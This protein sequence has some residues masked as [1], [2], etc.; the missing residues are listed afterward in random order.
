VIDQF[1]SRG[2]A[3]RDRL[4]PLADVPRRYSLDGRVR[5]LS[6]EWLSELPLRHGEPVEARIRFETMSPV[7]AVTVGIGFSNGEGTRLLTYDSDFPDGSRPDFSDPGIFSVDVTIG[8]LP[9]GPDIYNLDVGCRSGDV[10]ALDYL[11]ACQQVEV[12]AGPNTPVAIA[13]KGSAVRLAGN[14]SW[15]AARPVRQAQA[16][17]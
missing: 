3:D 6:L 13:I 11:P 12:I 1:M 10:H 16:V 2:I 15:E 5:I 14:W 17:S 4:V 8:A 9:L 7:S